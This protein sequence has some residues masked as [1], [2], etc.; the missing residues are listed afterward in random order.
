MS[1]LIYGL[2]ALAAVVA[3]AMTGSNPIF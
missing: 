1:H 2:I 3:I